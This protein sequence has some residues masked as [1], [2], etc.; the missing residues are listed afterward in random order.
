MSG[1]DEDFIENII[2]LGRYRNWRR[3][4]IKME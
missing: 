3:D 4:N 1:K 2:P